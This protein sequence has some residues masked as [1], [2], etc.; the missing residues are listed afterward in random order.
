[1]RSQPRCGEAS[2]AHPDAIAHAASFLRPP[3]APF[4]ILDPCAGQGAAVRQLA[5]LLGCP[6]AATYAIELDEHR[7][8]TVHAA[9]PEAHVLAPASF[10]GCQA[11]YNSLSLTWLNPPFDDGY[12]GHRVEEQFLLQATEWLMPGGV[13]A[14]VCPEDVMDEYSEAREHFAIYYEKVKIVPFPEH[15]RPYR[16]VVVLAHKRARPHLDRHNSPLES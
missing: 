14:F 15:C 10:F 16:E 13:M 4:S 7:A 2:T 1:M 5:E 11:S 3:L 9:L 8:D 12:A 6:P